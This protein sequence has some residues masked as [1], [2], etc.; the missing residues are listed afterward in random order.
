MK[1]LRFISGAAGVMVLATALGCS[2]SSGGTAS[3]PP[4]PAYVTTVTALVQT[5][6]SDSADPVDV[7]TLNLQGLDTADDDTVFNS[8]IGN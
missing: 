5:M 2:S 4:P 3:T 7:D 8:V 6:S 1:T